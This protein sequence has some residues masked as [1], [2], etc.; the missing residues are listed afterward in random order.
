[1]G[2]HVILL[3]VVLVI[4]AALG[5]LLWR[6]RPQFSLRALMI[7]CGLVAGAFSAWYSWQW[8]TLARLAWIDPSSPE[9]R[10][11]L[12]EPSI[13]ETAGK[14]RVTFRPRHCRMSELLDV[15]SKHPVTHSLNTRTGYQTHEIDLESGDRTYL[16]TLLAAMQEADAPKPGLRVIHGRVEDASGEPVAGATVDL[17]GSYVYINHFQTRSDGTFA[18]LIEAPP[19]SGY[20]LRIRYAGDTKRMET[21]SFSLA[22]NPGEMMMSVRVK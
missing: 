11:I 21:P 8:W 12:P 16:D 2:W 7:G 10:R 19:Q 5:V 18:M 15:A 6:R 9:A 13:V 4:S 14:F 1:M 3:A 20:R 17:L 22:D